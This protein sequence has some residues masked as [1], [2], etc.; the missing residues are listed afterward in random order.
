MIDEA[1]A[2]QVG[3]T[4]DLD[5]KRQLPPT[6]KVATE[7]DFCK[8]IA[9]MANSGGGTILYGVTE[10][11]KRATGRYDVEL[12]EDHERTLRRAAISSI[13]PPVH[14]LRIERVEDTGRSAVAITVGAS[15]EPPHMIYK[16]EY[17]GAPWRNDADT[18][19]ANEPQLESMYRSR[20][21]RRRDRAEE[22][23]DLY[24][25]TAR[26][27]DT[28]VRAWLIATAYPHQPVVRA[29]RLSREDARTCYINAER[30]ALEIADRLRA[31]HPLEFMDRTNPRPG[32]RSWVAPATVRDQAAWS[33]A[34]A[35]IGDSGAI[36]LAA[37]VGGHR[38]PTEDFWSGAR[39]EVHRIEGAVAD[40]AGLLRATAQQLGTS[41]YDLQIGVE[42]A[43][44]E[45]LEFAV[46][47]PHFADYTI[48]PDGS[49]P[50]QFEPVRS[51]VRAD[52]DDQQ[53]RRHVHELALDCVNQG[54]L[55]HTT[56][57]TAPG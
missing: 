39:A 56:I 32:L 5:F 46:P 29:T 14:G 50:V 20:F 24:A 4:D 7:S 10:A 1:V 36:T 3:E 15:P 48:A 18:E 16:G 6:A 13:R 33:E 47:D 25:R 2:E 51:T 53:F 37:T 22:L 9:A 27:R 30:P 34:W 8:D 43:G 41:D 49:S 31:I 28:T 52:A 55:A 57:I 11:N 38:R 42:W 40:F 35:S 44:D 26:G 54:G 12:T 23:C 19:W 45:R 21:D 17:F